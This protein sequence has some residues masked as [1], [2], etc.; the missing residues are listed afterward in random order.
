MKIILYLFLFLST[1]PLNAQDFQAYYSDVQKV[2][3]LY[4][5]LSL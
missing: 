5:I 3:E 2:L 4:L 1:I